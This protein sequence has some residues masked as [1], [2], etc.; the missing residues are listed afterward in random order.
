MGRGRRIANKHWAEHVWLAWTAWITR[1]AVMA[2]RTGSFTDRTRRAGSRRRWRIA[3]A[4]LSACLLIAFTASAASAEKSF[5]DFSGGAFQILAPGQEGGIPP[6]PFS[7]DQGELYNA[8]TPRKGHV[9]QANLEED[10]VSEKFGVSGPVMRSEATGR[11]GLEILRD[12]HDIP[13]IYGTTRG[14]VMFGSGWVAAEDRGLLLRL[15]LGPAFVAADGI[16][17]INAFQLLLSGRSFTPS[18]QSEEFVGEQKKTLTEKGPEGEQVVSDLEE[19]AE[20]INAYEQTL[21]PAQR[22]PHV[23]LTE[24]I[25]GFA[26]IGSIFGNG[27][28]N[29][30]SNSNLLAGLEAKYGETE[31]VPL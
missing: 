17:G 28:G 2:D 24:A 3:L 18:A 11:P 10:F 31:A 16:P 15:G 8:L 27:G 22:L 13:H 26:F 21:P 5:E 12:S 7:T 23:N 6:G 4:G 30:V 1:E 25:A 20:G 9:T 14:D 29:E 19:W